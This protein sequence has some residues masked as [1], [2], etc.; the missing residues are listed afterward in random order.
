MRKHHL[1]T[2]AIERKY[3]G[4][5]PRITPSY[6]T[7]NLAKLPA[8]YGTFE[9]LSIDNLLFYRFNKNDYLF[10]GGN[11]NGEKLSPQNCARTQ[12]EP[13]LRSSF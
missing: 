13:G 11:V 10:S 5:V 3:V 12:K 9:L 8:I 7:R 4:K 1:D 6:V 2:V